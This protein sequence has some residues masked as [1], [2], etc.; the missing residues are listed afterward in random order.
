MEVRFTTSLNLLIFHCSYKNQTGI[1]FVTVKCI[2][3][4]IDILKIAD[5][6]ENNFTIIIG[7]RSN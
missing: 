2:F 1:L 4:E 6:H 7:S 5:Q 3:V